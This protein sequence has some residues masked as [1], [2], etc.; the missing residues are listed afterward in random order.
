[1]QATSSNDDLP[2]PADVRAYYD[3]LVQAFA[4]GD[5]GALALL[6]DEA[7]ERPMTRDQILAW[8]EAF[9]GE[10]GPARFVVERVEVE[11]LGGESAVV[12]LTYRV[13]TKDGRG[14]FGGI[15]RDVLVRRGQGWTM[16]EWEAIKAPE[17][18]DP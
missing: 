17:R 4:A 6:F 2:L 14:S 9:F 7:I 8:G 1:M 16:A 10:H 12:L 13:E 5:A 18:A 3:E 15:E 11:R